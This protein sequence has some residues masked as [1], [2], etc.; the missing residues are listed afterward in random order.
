MEITQAEVKRLFNYD[1]EVGDLIRKIST[2]SRRD[3]GEIAGYHHPNG[4]IYVKID[5]G[6]YLIHRVIFIHVTGSLPAN[7]VDHINGKKDDNRWCNLRDVTRIENLKNQKV[8][9]S[10]SSG[11]MGVHWCKNQEKWISRIC[12]N[13]KNVCLGSF[14]DIQDAVRAREQANIKYGFHENHGR[15]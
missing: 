1:P 7:E 9:K 6:K 10:N 15:R 4:Y 14:S 2:K 11:F 8:R 12:N 13:S 5:S 3:K